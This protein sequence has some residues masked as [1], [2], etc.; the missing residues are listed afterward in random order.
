MSFDN[1]YPNRKDRRAPYRRSQR[2][3][4]S[5]RPHGGCGWCL[6]NRLHSSRRRAEAATYDDG[7]VAELV[8]APAS[9]PGTLEG[10]TPS[11]PTNPT[12][13]MAE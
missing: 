5:C 8:Y 4:K 10:S 7:G 11:A 12:G 13:G 3:D 9:K 1:R 2:F 6:G